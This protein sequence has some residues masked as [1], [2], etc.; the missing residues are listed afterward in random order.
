LDT[1]IKHGV[2]AVFTFNL[3][4][5]LQVMRKCKLFINGGGNLIQDSTSSRSLFFYLYTIFA[6]KRRGCKVLMYGCGIGKVR[7]PFNRKLTR[8]IIDKYADII[9]L[10]DSLSKEELQQMG[11]KNPEI[12]LTADPAMSIKPAPVSDADYYLKSHGI[13][14]DG[15]YICFSLREWKD[16]TDFSVF[17]KA[18]QYAYEKY[19]LTPVFLPIEV[20]KDL[21]VAKIAASALECPYH[22]LTPPLDASLLISVYGK[23]KAVCAVRL[24][25]LVFAAAS[26]AP[27]MAVSYDIK[28]DGFM[29]YIGREKMC[30]G[31][32]ELSYEWLC[33]CI[34]S[35]VSAD[36]PSSP[37]EMLRDLEKG[38]TDSVKQLMEK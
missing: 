34:D 24:H 6:A 9:T 1:S 19:N 13:D 2:N 21:E 18:A 32:S 29:E 7:R 30:K 27:F 16:F 4:K 36:A 33:R 8:V 11:I 10:R 20:P 38:N 22:I 25:A 35:I 31:L 3:F 26:G 15:N 28:V 12:K 17:S 14:P 5:F 37:A 23:M